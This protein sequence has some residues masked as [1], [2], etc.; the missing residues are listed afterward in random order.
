MSALHRAEAVQDRR[1]RVRDR[2]QQQGCL[3]TG[4]VEFS[5]DVRLRLIG[6]AAGLWRTKA[7]AP[8]PALQT[9]MDGGRSAGPVLRALRVG[10][11]GSASSVT[12]PTTAESVTVQSL[13]GWFC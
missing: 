1:S 7:T 10:T 9:A 8:Q 12:P 2:L 6:D 5:S 11:C 13:G 3:I 4:L